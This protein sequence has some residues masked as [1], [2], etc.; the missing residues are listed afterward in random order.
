VIELFAVPP[1][2]DAT[3]LAAWAAEAP[4]GSTLH[5]ALR[6]D[7]PHRFAGLASGGPDADGGVLLIVPFEIPEG[8]DE[9]FLAAWEAVRELF[10]ARRGYLGAQV[11]HSPD[12]R[13][14]AVVHWSSPLMYSRT[15]REEGDVIAALPVPGHP[16]L[17]IRVPG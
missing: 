7:V 6:A 4:P 3:F 8:E 12:A 5:R 10:S 2:E 1:D 9:R 16:A 14:V 13:S 11:L 15:V 17:Y